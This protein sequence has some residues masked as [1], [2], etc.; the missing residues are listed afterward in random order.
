MN[1]Q[2]TFPS[3]LRYALGENQVKLLNDGNAHTA[4]YTLTSVAS[5]LFFVEPLSVIQGDD[6]TI[7]N[8]TRLGVDKVK[9]KGWFKYF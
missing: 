3:V 6:L 2:E 1:H 4:D 7:K 9:P 5:C 8:E